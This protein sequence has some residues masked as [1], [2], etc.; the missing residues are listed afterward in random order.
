MYALFAH[1]LAP[2]YRGDLD[3]AAERLSEALNQAPGE[4]LVHSLQAIVHAAQNQTELALDCIRKALDSPSSFGHTHHAYNNIACAY[5]VL[6]QTD[7]ALGWLQRSIDTGFACWP[8][9]RI[10][11]YLKNLREEPRF[12]QLNADLEQKYTALEIERL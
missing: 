3:L 2:L 8:F 5:A 11:P 9:F 12:I 7:K 1:A 10:D 4:P 6:G